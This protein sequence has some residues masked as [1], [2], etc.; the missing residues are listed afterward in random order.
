MKPAINDIKSFDEM[1][2]KYAK[3]ALAYARLLLGNTG[4]AEDCTQEVFVS[5]WKNRHLLANVSSM[6]SYILRAI[7]NRAL[8][9]ITR[10][11]KSSESLDEI[12]QAGQISMMR[13]FYCSPESA[14]INKIYSKDMQNALQK[15]IDTLSPREKE[16][17]Q[18]SYIEDIPDKEIGSRLGLSVRTV[19]NHMYQ[20][21]R[22][23]RADLEANPQILDL[24]G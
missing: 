17:F 11:M 23:L 19:Q 13:Y 1:Y 9:Y 12:P 4:W 7:H 22:K 16:I 18:M 3:S 10:S 2:R 5:I 6:D 21:L 8:N 20:A 14:I 24:Q 15:A